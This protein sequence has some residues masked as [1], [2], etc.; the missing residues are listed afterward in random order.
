MGNGI[1][2]W[3][4]QKKIGSPQYASILPVGSNRNAT[5]TPQLYITELVP[6]PIA[7]TGVLVSDDRKKVTLEVIGHNARVHDLLRFT[8]GDL[9]AWEFPICEVFDPNTLTIWNV[10][11]D[12]DGNEILPAVADTVKSFRW[13]TAT[14]SADG[15]LTVSPGP[16]KFVDGVEKTVTPLEPLPVTNTLSVKE[17]SSLDTTANPV[18]GAAWVEFVAAT[19]S[20]IKKIQI[21]VPSG[22]ALY[23]GVGA[24]GVEVEAAIIAPGGWDIELALP[25]GEK[26]SL[27]AVSGIANDGLIVA[28]LLG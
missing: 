28:N 5:P 26:L 6:N 23:L 18:D 19:I 20:A 14:S 27:K 25:A 3:S 24:T 9:T 17:Y 22:A 10:G 11:D 4:N 21:F 13:V 1:S 12:N 7:I 16:V 2:G 15:A 8:S